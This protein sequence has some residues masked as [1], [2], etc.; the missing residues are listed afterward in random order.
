MIMRGT[1]PHHHAAEC[2]G[3]IARGYPLAVVLLNRKKQQRGGVRPGG[4]P[5]AV[6]LLNGKR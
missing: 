6:A 3:M 1:G 4:Q 2:K 5:L